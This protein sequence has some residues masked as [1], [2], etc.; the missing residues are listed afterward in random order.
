MISWT[1]EF[2]N[3]LNDILL[4]VLEYMPWIQP[5]C[6]QLENLILEPILANQS[7]S[8]VRFNETANII[9]TREYTS[10]LEPIQLLSTML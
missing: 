1:T 8:N 7:V 6:R 2:G 3:I 5:L 10:S 9:Y 4:V